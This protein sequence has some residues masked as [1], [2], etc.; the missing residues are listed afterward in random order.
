MILALAMAGMVA[1]MFISARGRTAQAWASLAGMAITMGPALVAA[2]W[3][4]RRV[5]LERSRLVERGLP[6]REAA[7]RAAR[8]ALWVFAPLTVGVGCWAA[9]LWW[10]ELWLSP[11]W[12]GVA[13]L[14]AVWLSIPMFFW[15]IG[16]WQCW[17]ALW[18]GRITGEGRH[19]ARCGEPVGLNTLPI[20][21]RCGR[22]YAF[23]SDVTDG[24]LSRPKWMWTVAI[25]AT[26]APASVFIIATAAI[27]VPISIVVR[28][29]ATLL[30]L[31]AQ[32]E[33][34]E[35][36]DAWDELHR[37][38]KR[39]DQIAALTEAALTGWER[40]PDYMSLSNAKEF[41]FARAVA[42]ELSEEQVGRLL[43]T[44]STSRT[45]ASVLAWDKI[46]TT[47]PLAPREDQWARAYIAAR[48]I[49]A[50]RVSVGDPWLVRIAA[51]GALTAETFDRMR[52]H[53]ADR[54]STS[55]DVARTLLHAALADRFGNDSAFPTAHPHLLQWMIE[56]RDADRLSPQQAEVVDRLRSDADPTT[57]AP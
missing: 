39:P 3:I 25:F 11:R 46:L 54:S 5:G 55:W 27:P 30:R 19:C 13:W 48:Q 32:P 20:C 21:A 41:L 56:E 6:V 35:S 7:A 57:K 18:F 29:S 44:L 31:V 33:L 37:R 24:R 49:G 16:A 43:E 53:L 26:A 15:A 51:S 14:Q 22:V 40:A 45:H 52:A 2:L 17:M 12:S 9:A 1:L 47:A 4:S 34:R 28:P 36:R 42:D 50:A 38:A 23:G 8:N 10:V